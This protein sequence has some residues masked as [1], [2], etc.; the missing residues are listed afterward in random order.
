ML[1]Q[2]QK[3]LELAKGEYPIVNEVL[4]TSEVEN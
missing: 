4:I 1:K 3:N 2:G